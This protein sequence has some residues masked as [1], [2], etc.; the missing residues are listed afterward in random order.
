[1]RVRI[2]VVAAVWAAGLFLAL[3]AHPAN[4][5]ANGAVPPEPPPN[6]QIPNP[7]YGNL[8]LGSIS[9]SGAEEWTQITADSTGRMFVSLEPAQFAPD[10]DYDLDVY[11]AEGQNLLAHSTF[12]P[13]PG[14]PMGERVILNAQPGEVFWVRVFGKTT[15]DYFAD[16]SGNPGYLLAVSYGNF[17]R[18]LSAG[19]PVTALGPATAEAP[20]GV[21]TVTVPFTNNSPS[22]LRNF[23]AEINV[24]SGGNTLLNADGPRTG[25]GSV[26][27][28]L[29]NTALPSYVYSPTQEIPSLD[30][31]ETFTATFQIGL[32]TLSPFSL[33]VDVY[34]TRFEGS[35]VVNPAAA[36]AQGMGPSFQFS[37]RPEAATETNYLY[38]PLLHH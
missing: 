3:S 9:A 4:A 38:L 10:K 26:L 12:T 37:F 14:K 33:W 5:G 27:L 17:N 19:Q 13:Q 11:D 16:P 29:S 24:L 34:G 8:R 20:A 32:R 18:L 30:P 2:T 23:T 31:G 28:S 7:Q 21:F 35:S 6:A 25:D 15:A 1:M 36:R 22:V